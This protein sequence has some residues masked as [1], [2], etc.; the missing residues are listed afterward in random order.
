[1]DRAFFNA[2]FITYI[3]L[4]Q[5][6]QFNEVLSQPIFQMDHVSGFHEIVARSTFSNYSHFT[7]F[8]QLR[9]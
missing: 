1:M 8:E 5:F 6:V 2:E 3:K 7:V 9:N 4:A